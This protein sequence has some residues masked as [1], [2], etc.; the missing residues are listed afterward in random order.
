[1]AR[2]ALIQ[3]RRDTAANWTSVNPVL[4]AGEPGL[5]TDTGKVK[6]GDGTTAW[7]SL[8]YATNPNAETKHTFNVK[9]YGA[10]GDGITDDSG[11]INAAITAANAAGGGI[12]QLATQ[13]YVALPIIPLSNIW[14]R[15]LGIDLTTIFTSST[16]TGGNGDGI[17]YASAIP[18]NYLDSVTITDLTIDGSRGY[19]GS[20]LGTFITPYSNCMTLQGSN[21]LWVGRGGM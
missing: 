7:T 2:K 6:Y 10:V 12:I 5:E 20:P 11:A 1:M 8:A 3:T 16:E 19:I 18:A 17:R 4:A 21:N 14:L 9:D 15:G 13:H